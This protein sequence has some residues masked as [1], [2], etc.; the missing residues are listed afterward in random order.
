MSRKVKAQE[1]RF[2]KARAVLNGMAEFCAQPMR[3]VRA[4]IRILSTG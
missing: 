3:S 2:D 4:F 1:S